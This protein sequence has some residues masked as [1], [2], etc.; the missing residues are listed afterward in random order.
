MPTSTH[1]ISILRCQHWTAQGH[2][3]LRPP[4]I[5]NYTF[6]WMPQTPWREYELWNCGWQ[7]FPQM[8]KADVVF[9]DLRQLARGLHDESRRRRRSSNFLFFHIN[10]WWT[11]SPGDQFFILCLKHS[12]LLQ[13]LT[14]LFFYQIWF[15]WFLRSR[16]VLSLPGFVVRP[17][18]TVTRWRHD[19]CP[20]LCRC[21]TTV[22]S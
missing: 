10:A 14:R 12:D 17:L 11:E 1:R 18:L 21:L 5:V 13:R 20:Q 6:C 15:C 9:L 8:G 2:I 7:S 16:V 22:N 19:L 4:F 3:R